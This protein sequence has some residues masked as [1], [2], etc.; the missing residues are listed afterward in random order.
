MKEFTVPEAYRLVQRSELKEI[1]LTGTVL[2]HTKSGARLI[3]LPSDDDNKV[4]FIAF[5][6]PPADDSGLPH[7]LEHSV[8]CGS[9]KYPIK[10]PFMELGK[11]SLNTFLNAMTYPDKTIYPVASCNDKDFANLMD[12]YMDAVLH[13]Q[14]HR[15]KNIFLQEGWRYELESRDA[16]LN[17]NGVVYSEMKG[18]FSDPEEILARYALNSLYP[19][20]A[21]RY[22]SGGDPDAIPSLSYESFCEFHKRLYHPANSYIFLY[23]DMDMEERL[24]YLDRSYLSAYDRIEVDSEP[25]FQPPFEARREM[26]VT[27]PVSEEEEDSDKSFYSLQWS[28]GDIMDSRLANAMGILETV[29]I[30]APGAP[31][32]QALLDAGLAKDAGGGYAAYTLQPQ[33]NVTAKEAKAGEKARFMQIVTDTLTELADKGLNRKSLAAAI[34]SREF[35]SREADFGGFSKGLVYGINILNTWLYD[36]EDPFLYLRYEDV[37]AFLRAKIEEGYFESVIRQHLLD[38][39]HC[40]LVEM[41]PEKG[42]DKRDSEALQKRLEAYKS[43]LSESEQDALIAQYKALKAYQE[44]EESPEEKRCVPKLNLSDLKRE[45][46]VSVNREDTAGPAKLITRPESTAGIAYADLYFDLAAVPQEHLP[47]LGLLKCCFA[48]VSTERQNYRDLFDSIQETTGGISFGLDAPI[49]TSGEWKP[50]AAVSVKALYSRWKESL[51][52]IR[53]ICLGSLF[54]DEKRLYEILSSSVIGQRQMMLMAGHRAAIQ[55]ASSYYDET[56][57]FGEITGGLDFFRFCSDALDDFDGR[58]EELMTGLET[59]SSEVFTRSGLIFNLTCESEALDDLKKE[60]ADLA[61]SLPESPAACFTA[62]QPVKKNEGIMTTGAVGFV[63]MCGS[64]RK[65]GPYTGALRVL[66]TL[67]STD[68]LWQQLR[69]L[70]GAYGA[71]CSFSVMGQSYFASYRDPNIRSTR[72]AYL[73]IP[74]YLETLDLP[75]EILDNFIISTIGTLDFPFTPSVLGKRDFAAY[76]GGIT[77]GMQQQERTQI[78][79]CRNEDLR[80]LAPYVQC[81]LQDNNFCTFGSAVAIEKDRDLF[82]NT[83]NL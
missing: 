75:R 57:R 24:N 83:E 60:L 32:K 26:D 34:S 39:P 66:N 38:N 28:V 12:V 27:Y 3:C 62:P 14:I 59:V 79:N 53:E 78:L 18:A 77:A 56:F 73:A 67:L 25:G 80:A 43:S 9:D 81:I 8:L 58:K 33:F 74:A 6:T 64:F 47:Y 50:Y 70:G 36:G 63:A 52:L 45:A 71:M 22:E 16:E 10:D 51:S 5:R 55:R 69:V 42:K 82:E 7:I 2:E 37:F 4:F 23:G 40:T 13:P 44:K 76:L 21:Y 41:D 35:Q 49:R 68:Y 46:R 11:S 48:L 61:A 1:G 65:A 19:D 17:L 20:T 29:L 30:T 15:N 72:D 31:L 54:R